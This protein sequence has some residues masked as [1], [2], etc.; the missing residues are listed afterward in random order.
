MKL[1]VADCSKAFDDKVVLDG[2]DL[3]VSEHEVVCL[4][5]ASGSGKSTLLKAINLLVPI[6][7]GQIFLDGEDITAEHVNANE[8]RARMGIVFQ[9]F[10]LFPHLKV[11]DNVTLAPR[12]VRNLP[13][14]QAVALGEELLGRFGLADKRNEY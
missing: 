1:V 2:L 11:I 6:D 13:T 10:N 9:S 14:R 12:K 8:V 7:S 4:V 5:G 3:E